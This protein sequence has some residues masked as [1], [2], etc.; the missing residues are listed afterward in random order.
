MSL[1]VALLVVRVGI[2]LALYAFLA[3]IL[4][5]LMQDVRLASQA[6]RPSQHPVARLIVVKADGPDIEVG[7]EFVLQPV[8]TL[9]RG[10]MN[11]IVLPDSF[12][13]VQHAQIVR[14][15][16]QWW[17]EDQHSRNGT[18]VNDIPVT[19]TVVL[20]SGDQIGIGRVWFRLELD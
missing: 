11:T 1:D 13:S 15:R 16:D 20:S 9:G 17:I 4:I 7:R 2:A 10:P 5:Y 14:R 12:A 6:A 3:V 19:G 18:T 8:T